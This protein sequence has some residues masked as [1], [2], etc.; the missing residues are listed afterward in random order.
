M[1]TSILIKIL[2]TTLLIGLVV[3]ASGCS[4]R[5][6]TQSTTSKKVP[7]GKAKKTAGEKSAKRFAPGQ[8][9]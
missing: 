9:K 1:K 3:S 4:A 2:I 5:V 6:G 7:P 8:N